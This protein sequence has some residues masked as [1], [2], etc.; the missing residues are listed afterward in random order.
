MPETVMTL[1]RDERKGVSSPGARDPVQR[2]GKERNKRMD[3][4][5]NWRECQVLHRALNEDVRRATWGGGS[6]CD[7]ED[8]APLGFSWLA[9]NSE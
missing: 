4:Q 6:G 9:N 2:A 7:G 5:G 3:R 1:D 8:P